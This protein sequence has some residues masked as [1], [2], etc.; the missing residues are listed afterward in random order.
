MLT[1]TA[2]S[3][4]NTGMSS[5]S[6]A[7]TN[8]TSSTALYSDRLPRITKK[9]LF[10][11]LAL[12]MEDFPVESEQDLVKDNEATKRP[13]S[14]HRKVGA[15]L[16]LRDT[17]SV[18]ESVTK[19]S[20]DILYAVDC[21]RDGVHGVARLLMNN[22]DVAKGCKVFVSRK[23]CS[24]CTKLL[25][26]SK[27]K[28]VYFPPF[29]PEYHGVLKFTSEELEKFTSSC[30]LPV[31]ASQ[32]NVP[33]DS[34]KDLS[35]LEM[36]TRKSVLEKLKSDGVLDHLTTVVIEN[37]KLEKSSELEESISDKAVKLALKQFYREKSQVEYLFKKSDVNQSVLVPKVEEA[38]L[39]REKKED[40]MDNI[41]ER[42]MKDDKFC[43]E[44]C[45]KTVKLDNLSWAVFDEYM[46]K[47][48]EQDF[49]KAMEWMSRILVKSGLKGDAEICFE[50]VVVGEKLNELRSKQFAHLIGMAQFLARRTDHDPKKGVGAVIANENM[51]IKALGW[52]GFPLKAIDG[53]FPR[54]YDDNNDIEVEDFVIHAEQNAF[55]MRNDKNLKDGTL[56]VTK[57]PCD[58]CVPLIQMQGIKTVVLGKQLE[59]KV[60]ATFREKVNEGVI[61]CYELHVHIHEAIEGRY[62]R[63][64]ILIIFC[65][66]IY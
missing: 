60:P 18:T 6:A 27:V 43:K 32:S 40:E 31:L 20:N 19:P 51:E 61:T 26:Q 48:F 56:F 25:V 35:A 1:D 62:R 21:T 30:E 8:N 16:V 39:Q 53:E 4:S 65:I 59:T 14:G 64:W 46:E 28:M 7:S 33:A 47:K 45:I 37:L 23:P 13:Y 50:P 12:W 24:F 66:I 52:N 2:P 22:P 10:M 54:A 3:T 29:E 34:N 38:V 5:D 41:K 42:K 17:K 44:D 49:P 15:V 55:L 58:E 9:D 63:Y 57:T 36:H 11:L